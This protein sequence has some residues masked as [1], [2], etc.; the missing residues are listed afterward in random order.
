MPT[1]QSS[2]NHTIK[3]R[4]LG[5]KMT[6]GYSLTS[7]PSHPKPI[8]RPG[9]FLPCSAIGVRQRRPQALGD[10]AGVTCF[11]APMPQS[12]NPDGSTCRGDQGELHGS[13]LTRDPCG[14]EAFIGPRWTR[15]HRG[16]PVSNFF[17]VP[18]V[19]PFHW[20]PSRHHHPQAMLPGLTTCIER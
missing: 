11:G 9:V 10:P 14:S 2:P 18:M 17:V 12:S 15:Q 16:I 19:D 1:I 7:N 3:V 8:G 5:F 13:Y 20:A 4:W 6:K